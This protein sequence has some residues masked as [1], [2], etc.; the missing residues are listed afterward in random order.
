[1]LKLSSRLVVL[2]KQQKSE[3]LSQKIRKIVRLTTN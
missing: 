3:I 1:M 2:T